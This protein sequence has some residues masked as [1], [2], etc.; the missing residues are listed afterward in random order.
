MSY[1][2]QETSEIRVSSKS[3]GPLLQRHSLK[4]Q[5]RDANFHIQWVQGL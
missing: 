2:T 3:T 4:K 1:N 5:I